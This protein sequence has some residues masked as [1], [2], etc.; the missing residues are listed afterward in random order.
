VFR[1][2]WGGGITVTRFANCSSVPNEDAREIPYDALFLH[3]VSPRA[4]TLVASDAAIRVSAW[5]DHEFGTELPKMGGCDG[6][7]VG[8]GW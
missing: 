5:N 1:V 6:W 4:K 2:L 3:P 8:V 7:G